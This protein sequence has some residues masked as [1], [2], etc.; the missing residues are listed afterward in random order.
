MF[1]RKF[2][3]QLFDN[4]EMKGTL[5]LLRF[6]SIVLFRA[7]GIR[8]RKLKSVKFLINVFELN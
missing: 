2:E 6:L 3:N 5:N 1:Q 8:E 4:K 7:M